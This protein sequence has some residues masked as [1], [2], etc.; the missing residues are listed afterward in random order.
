MMSLMTETCKLFFSYHHTNI[1]A[2]SS[3]CA[4]HGRLS[5]ALRASHT[6]WIAVD[7]LRHH[8]PLAKSA[9]FVLKCRE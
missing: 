3:A 2:W 1:G 6:R 4:W 5:T 7:R 8:L 9:V